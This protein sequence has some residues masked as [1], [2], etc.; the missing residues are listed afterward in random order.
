MSD[1]LDSGCFLGSGFARIGETR[2]RWTPRSELPSPNRLQ[3][4]TK[5][6]APLRLMRVR[7]RRAAYAAGV[8][9]QRPLMQPGVAKAAAEA[10]QRQA[11]QAEY[12]TM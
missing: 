6:A 7:S 8:R 12:A 3:R 11:L 1:G 4:E 5:A 9:R 2:A 10:R